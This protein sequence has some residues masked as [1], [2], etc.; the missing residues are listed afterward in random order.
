MPCCITRLGWGRA[1]SP[2]AGQTSCPW[3]SGDLP[4]KAVLLQA[5][6]K[7]CFSISGQTLPRPFCS[8]GRNQTNIGTIMVLA[9]YSKIIVPI[10]N[11]FIVKKSFLS[12]RFRREFQCLY[13][14]KI[15]T[16]TISDHFDM[17]NL[18]IWSCQRIDSY[19][20]DGQLDRIR[21][22]FTH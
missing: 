20:Q 4:A 17:S 11:F 14:T 7:I 8:F 10:F 21:T 2:K 5:T 3:D 19:C 22:C 16:L 15:R 9:I 12:K 1:S 18:L 6:T 13:W